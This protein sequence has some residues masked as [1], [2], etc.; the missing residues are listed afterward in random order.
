[1]KVQLIITKAGEPAPRTAPQPL[2]KSEELDKSM[3]P[4]Q[5]FETVRKNIDCAMQKGCN[6]KQA[7]K[8]AL[9][10]AGI[11]KM[12]FEGRKNAMTVTKSGDMATGPDMGG[13]TPGPTGP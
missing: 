6:P 9:T 2:S 5:D 1:M 3:A 13:S 10:K 4:G 7:V 12:P 11:D 8:A